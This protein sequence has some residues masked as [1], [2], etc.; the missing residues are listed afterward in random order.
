MF[1]LHVSSFSNRS[2]HPPAISF[3]IFLN[4]FS[5]RCEDHI[6]TVPIKYYLFNFLDFLY[7]PVS[8]YSPPSRFFDCTKER[9][10]GQFPLT[11]FILKAH[12]NMSKPNS[13]ISQLCIISCVIEVGKTVTFTLIYVKLFILSVSSNYAFVQISVLINSEENYT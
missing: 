12:T 2:P 3:V 5:S 9:C 8:S 1:R 4:I 10:Y 6:P 7:V 13:K 11:F